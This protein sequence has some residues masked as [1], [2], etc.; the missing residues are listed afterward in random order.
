MEK[1]FPSTQILFT[2][3]PNPLFWSSVVSISHPF[4]TCA[5]K[6][7][8]ATRASSIHSVHSNK[9]PMACATCA[10]AL[11]LALATSALTSPAARST[12]RSVATWRLGSMVG[13]APSG[14]PGATLPRQNCHLHVV[15]CVVLCMSWVKSILRYSRVVCRIFKVCLCFEELKS[16]PIVMH[17]W[18]IRLRS[19][20]LRRTYRPATFKWAVFCF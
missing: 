1:L 2:S 12:A 16:Y 3:L 15:L 10:A 5:G 20:S 18:L 4:Q 9:S 17:K 7:S 14:P 6:T 19:S 11:A 8:C 13:P